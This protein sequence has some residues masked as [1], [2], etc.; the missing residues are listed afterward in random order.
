MTV[1]I[2]IERWPGAAPFEFTQWC[3][4]HFLWR[5]ALRNTPREGGHRI[6]T[7]YMINT[8]SRMITRTVMIR[9]RPFIMSLLSL[10]G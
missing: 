2:A 4:A 10:V 1:H 7:K 3:G 6:Q 9:L 8:T 5:V